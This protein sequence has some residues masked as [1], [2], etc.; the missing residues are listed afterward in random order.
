MPEESGYGDGPL[1]W[2]RRL[3][4]PWLERQDWRPEDLADWLQG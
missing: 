4:I 2:M 3:V 1:G